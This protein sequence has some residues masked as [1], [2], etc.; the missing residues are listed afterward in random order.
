MSI[1]VTTIISSTR[2]F[3]RLSKAIK[4][5]NDNLYG[6]ELF[7]DDRIEFKPV[8]DTEYNLSH[9]EVTCTPLDMFQIG[10]RYGR[11]EENEFLRPYV[12]ESFKDTLCKPLETSAL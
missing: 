11:Q 4:E 2:S 9:F 6:T 8:F 7:E 1:K 5:L 3:A 12:R 10:V